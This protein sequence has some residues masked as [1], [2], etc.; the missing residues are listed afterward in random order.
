MS[1]LRRRLLAEAAG[2]AWVVLIGCGSMV[3]SA[4]FGAQGL[5]LLG[6]SLAFGL[7]FTS[8]A[9]AIWPIS[10][11]H[12]N[13]AVTVGFAVAQRF[14][15][16]ELVPYLAAQVV[17]AALGAWLLAYIAGGRPGF[18]LA[19]AEFGANGYGDH[20]P[21]DYRLHAAA[22]L[23]FAMSFALVMVHLLVSGLRVSRVIAPPAVGAC[24]TLIYLVS[25]PVTNGSANP[26]RST[27][28]ALLVG[29]WALDQLWMFWAA[30]MAA[31]ILAGLLYPL[32][33]GNPRERETGALDQR[34]RP[35]VQ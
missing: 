29:G 11:A 34:Q 18:E 14:S 32:F 2:S 19:A 4:N 7:G 9:Y 22:A 25:L 3:L 21:F 28:P 35:A 17:G 16:R 31:A 26:A 10:G 6:V 30:P 1:N 20:S 12:M 33:Q 24:I 8:M 5:G 23:E 15:I 27:G 13:P